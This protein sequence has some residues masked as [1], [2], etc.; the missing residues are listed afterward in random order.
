MA[1]GPSDHSMLAHARNGQMANEILFCAI[2]ATKCHT[3]IIF[4][5]R[6]LPWNGITCPEGP[7]FLGRRSPKNIHLLIPLWPTSQC[8]KTGSTVI[9]FWHEETAHHCHIPVSYQ[10]MPVS[11]PLL[12][13]LSLNPTERHSLSKGCTFP[14]LWKNIANL[15]CF[16]WSI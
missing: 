6:P 5:Q 1:H 4:L 2:W 12:I 15:V 8:F 10:T 3:V 13:G 16:P 11:S 14:T 7:H 9:D